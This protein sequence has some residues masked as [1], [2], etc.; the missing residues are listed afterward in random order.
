MKDSS[1]SMDLKERLGVLST[2]DAPKDLEQLKS[3]SEK[4]KQR[5]AENNGIGPESK[6]LTFGQKAVGLTF[7]PSGDPRVV[8]AKQLIADAI[9]LLEEVH[10]EKTDNGAASSTWYRNVFRTE[11]FNQLVNA[12][13][14]LVKYLTWQD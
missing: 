10:Q 9:D 8:K 6:V 13:S 14:S 2:A 3:M 11:A 1:K 12:S 4:E 7:N 5:M